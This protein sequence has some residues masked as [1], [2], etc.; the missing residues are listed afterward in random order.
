MKKVF[1]VVSVA[2]IFLSSCEVELR[3]E[4]QYRHTRGYEHHHH[5]DHHDP[6]NH[7]YHHD[8]NGGEIIIIH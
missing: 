2:A 8:K 4:H 1:L 3:E 7:G 6:Y 5:P